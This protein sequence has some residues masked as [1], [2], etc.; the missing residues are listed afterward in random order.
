MASLE[1]LSSELCAGSSVLRTLRDAV[2]SR[3]DI[4]LNGTNGVGT[5]TGISMGIGFGAAVEVPASDLPPAT[6]S[7]CN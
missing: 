2:D 5:C 3:A 6:P 7:A 4:F 1:G